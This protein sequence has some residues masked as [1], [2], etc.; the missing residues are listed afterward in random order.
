MRGFGA[1][2][3]LF[4]TVTVAA[5]FGLRLVES[6]YGLAG[7][8][9][10]WHHFGPLIGAAVTSLVVP[11]TSRPDPPEPVARRQWI[12]HTLLGVGAAVLFALLLMLGFTVLDVP[13]PDLGRAGFGTIVI[14]MLG[15]LVGA[16]AQEVGWRGFLQ[17]TLEARTSRIWASVVVGLVWTLWHVTAYTDLVTGGL[18]LASYLPMAVLL[19]HLGNGS[20]VQ[21]VTTT[22]LVHWLVTVPVMLMAGIGGSVVQ[23]VVA[24]VSVVVT[25]LFMAMFLIAV[26]RRRARAR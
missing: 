10:Q 6:A 26:K 9:I 19:G 22:T 13:A 17:P 1:S 7:G 12:A 14:A 16:F 25:A 18:L 4:L 11:A 5:T 15:L 23:A 2:L 24:A 3:I 21:R 20:V 8:A